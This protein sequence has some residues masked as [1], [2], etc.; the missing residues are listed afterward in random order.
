METWNFG[1]NNDA[2][3][4][5]VLSGIKTATTYLNNTKIPKIG[6][7]SILVFDNEKKACVVETKDV[8]VIKFK[9]ITE[10]MAYLEGEGDRTLNYYK[11]SHT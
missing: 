3:V 4:E 1:I 10:E 6:E 7:K 11:Q 5:L 8:K 2:L 9:D